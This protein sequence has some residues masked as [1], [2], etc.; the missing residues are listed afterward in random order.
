MDWLG[1]NGM[2]IRLLGIGLELGCDF[3]HTSACIGLK[4][5]DGI[6]EA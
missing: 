2:A 1:G 5:I 3:P 4:M 6:S